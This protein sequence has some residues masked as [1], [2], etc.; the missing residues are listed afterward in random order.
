MVYHMSGKGEYAD[1]FMRMV[2]DGRLRSPLGVYLVEAEKK[3][4]IAQFLGLENFNS[5]GEALEYLAILTDAR[6]GKPGTYSDRMAVHF[7][8]EEVAD[9][10]YG[11]EKGNEIF[12]AFPSAHVASQYYFNGQLNEHGG[13]Y[14]NDQWVWANEE[15][16]LDLNAGLVFIPEEARVDP[17]TGSRY[18]LNQDNNPII[19]S[20][21][22]AAYKKVVDSP[23]YNEWAEQVMKITGKLSLHSDKNNLLPG[24]QELLER[25]E[26]FRQRL[27][28]EFGITDRR[29]QDAI[30]DF[31]N[32]SSLVVQKKTQEEGESTIQSVETLIDGA[33]QGEGILFKETEHA[34]SSKDFWEAYFEKYPERRPSKIVYYKGGDP[35]KALWQWRKE[36]GIRKRTEDKNLGFS[37]RQIERSSPRATSGFDRFKTLAEKVIEDHFAK[38][39]V[40]SD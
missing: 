39:K 7:A 3:L 33:L 37:E 34:I 2:E 8:T 22:Q 18:E 32:L 20:D 16:G 1:G 36:H 24:D 25:L 5:E 35:T 21:Y 26:P 30:L 14:W 29:L 17:K 38:R 6:Q 31:H 28:Q 10:Y 23:N 13:G 12:I 27:E 15:R 9:C 11:S 4:A 19:N 40:A